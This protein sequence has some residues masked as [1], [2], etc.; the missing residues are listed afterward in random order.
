[1]PIR[2]MTRYAKIV[3]APIQSRRRTRIIIEYV[4]IVRAL[5][6]NLTPVTPLISTALVLPVYEKDLSRFVKFHF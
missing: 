2:I 4:K 1:M 3:R 5:T 6:T